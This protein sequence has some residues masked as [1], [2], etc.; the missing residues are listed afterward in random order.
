VV[1]TAGE[2][3]L[4]QVVDLAPDAPFVVSVDL[5]HG[6][7]GPD[8][9]LRVMAADGREV[10]AYRPARIEASEPPAPATEPPLPG[11]VA[12]IEELFLVGRHL[13]Q[14][15]HAT[16]G[17]EPYWRE[18]LR[19]DP[20]DSRCNTA[21]GA[22]HLRRG[23]FVDAERHLRAAIATLT[24][25]NPNPADG[26][27]LYLLGVTLRFAGRLDEAE[28]AFAKATWNAAWQPA[29]ESGLATIHARRGDVPGALAALDRALGADGRNSWARVLRAT[30][31][32]RAGRRDEA[33]DAVDSVL[34]EDPLDAWALHERELLDRRSGTAL[35]G[36]VQV[37]LDVAHDYATA[38]LF[39]DAI[40]VLSRPLDPERPDAPVHP[41]V[42]YT[43]AWAFDRAGNEAA[44][45]RHATLGRA[46]PP[47]LC[48]PARLEEIDVL[49]TAS[50]LD[51]TDPRAP[52]Y[53]GN[54]L[55]DRRR[56]DAAIRAWSRSRAL[57]PSFA[58]VHRNLG[59][60]AFNVRRR[61]KQARAAYV[62][63]LR[64]DPADARLLYEFDQ[65]RKRLGEPAEER[66]TFLDARPQLVARRDD[67]TIERL[68]LLNQLGRHEEALEGLIGR[69]FHPWEGGEGLVSGQW[70]AANLG[71]A[72]RALAEARPLA[73]IAAL[74]A[75]MAYPPNLGEGKHLL[76]PENEVQYL[77]GHAHRATG[78]EAAARG[79]FGM[80]ATAQG[81][82]SAPLGEPASWR[83][84]A[85]RELGHWAE[86]AALFEDLLRSARKR[87]RD[88]VRIDYFATSLPSLLLFD[89]DLGLRNRTA[90]RYLE[91][92]ALAGLGRVAA[93][94]RAFRAVLEADPNH[95]GA[96][97]RLVELDA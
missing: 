87:A 56:Y 83:A 59:I 12:T 22:W 89:D 71:L 80:A 62:R 77:L 94:R 52:Y 28:A 1:V 33:T 93:A 92:L 97:S 55:Y 13:E 47:E 73:A 46:M 95:T 4:D 86:A 67:L 60:A 74:E 41:L 9:E 37:H 29:A 36:G 23:E 66:L 43:I 51:P 88:E 82:P 64:A 48:F 42:H 27:A 58:T 5:A 3:V 35:P 70:V 85:L 72:R 26:E 16:R 11:D 53:L 30:L 90:C 20:G 21:L 65:L 78:D 15:R 96:R 68:T 17:P 39:D 19:R 10:I 8:L 91:G 14:Y 38:G 40:R 45:R 76:T 6:V 2:P 69:R 31:L 50:R 32:R 63:A 61:P 57:D 54:L 24:R 7:T 81:D 25:R 34:R 79:W 44:A 18:A 49:E 84:L 75:A